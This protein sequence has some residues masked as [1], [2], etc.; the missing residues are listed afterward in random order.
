V[1]P[2]DG[3]YYRNPKKLQKRRRKMSVNL[4]PPN[5][6]VERLGARNQ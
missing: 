3:H 4:A 5:E 1:K 6:K 2:A